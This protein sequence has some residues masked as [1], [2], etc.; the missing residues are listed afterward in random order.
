MC[1]AP[2]DTAHAASHICPLRS[3]WRSV[4]LR[5]A[6]ECDFGVTPT[7][8][9]ICA[10]CVA[11]RSLRIAFECHFGVIILHN[12]TPLYFNIMCCAEHLAQHLQRMSDH[13][14][15][16]YGMHLLPS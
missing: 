5:I 12:T 4:C 1:H 7:L 6:F 13:S 2:H 3:S 14:S 8:H 10:F 16:N 11:L 9:L 15:L